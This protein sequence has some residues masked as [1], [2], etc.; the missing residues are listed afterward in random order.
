MYWYILFVKTG[1]EYRVE[2]LLKEQL[3]TSMFMPFVPLQECLFKRAGIVKKEQ[4]PLFPGYIFIESEVAG[5]DFLQKISP[6]IYASSDIVC[7][8]KYSETEISMRESERQ[9]LLRL[10]N[11]NHC[12]EASCGIMEGDRI[13]IISGPLKGWESIIKKVNRHKRQA[14]VDIELMGEMR[15]VCIGLDIVKKI[16]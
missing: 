13:N 15:L 12:I 5:R 10:C 3:D 7:V 11:E 16:E 14:W 9:M 2:Q 4:K 6:L 1:R 8:L